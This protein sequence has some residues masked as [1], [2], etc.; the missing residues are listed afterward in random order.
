MHKLGH[1]PIHLSIRG[2]IMFVHGTEKGFTAPN[3]TGPENTG[4]YILLKKLRTTI[5]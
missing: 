3:A 4:G 1:L 2:E 5:A